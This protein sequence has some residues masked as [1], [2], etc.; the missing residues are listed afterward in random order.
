MKTISSLSLASTAVEAVDKTKAAIASPLSLFICS[1]SLS[2][3]WSYQ[4][5]EASDTLRDAV[6][7]RSNSGLSSNPSPGPGGTVIM[8]PDTAGSAVTTRGEEDGHDA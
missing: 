5:V 8:P 6:K 3:L 1:S 2:W 4:T 7:A